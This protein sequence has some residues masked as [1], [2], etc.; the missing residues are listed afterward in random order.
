MSAIDE[1]AA[2]RRRQ[3]AVEGWTP[4]HDDGHADGEIAEAAACYCIGK[5][6]IMA[7]TQKSQ[8]R[9]GDR[10]NLHRSET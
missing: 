2:E 5:T 9:N 7:Q 6:G 10:A 1:I 4:E 3:I 8:S